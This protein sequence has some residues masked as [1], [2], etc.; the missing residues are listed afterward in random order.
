M[1]CRLYV[2]AMVITEEIMEQDSTNQELRNLPK[3]TP[4]G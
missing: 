1:N 4:V 3:N 2:A